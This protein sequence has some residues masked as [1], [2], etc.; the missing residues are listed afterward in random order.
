[1]S[2]TLDQIAIAIQDHVSRATLD[3]DYLNRRLRPIARLSLISA[4]RE[5]PPPLTLEDID[6]SPSS[7]FCLNQHS[8]NDSKLQGE[9][10]AR[11]QQELDENAGNRGTQGA[12]NPRKNQQSKTGSHSNVYGYNQ[13]SKVNRKVARPP[14]IE[15]RKNADLTAKR[16]N[17]GGSSIPKR[18]RLS[19]ESIPRIQPLSEV[20]TNAKQYFVTK[21]MSRAE[22]VCNWDKLD[23]LAYI[24]PSS[25][26][27]P[28]EELD[29]ILKQVSSWGSPNIQA[30]FRRSVY[31]WISSKERGL[32]ISPPEHLHTVQGFDPR[33]FQQFWTALHIV[34][35]AKGAEVM[36]VLFRRKAL[37][38]L[39]IAYHNVMNHIRTSLTNGAVLQ[40]NEKVSVRARTILYTTLYP[41]QT[42]RSRM[43]SMFNYDQRCAAPYLRLYQHFQN[44]GMLAMI[45]SKTFEGDLQLVHRQPVMIQILDLLR[46]DLQTGQRLAFYSRVINMLFE[47]NVPNAAILAELDCWTKEENAFI[48]RLPPSPFGI[49]QTPQDIASLAD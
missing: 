22:G 43:K 17:D 34:K 28:F 23:E 35:G 11:I 46:P 18:S 6:A 33:P 32:N 27:K 25:K 49:S 14:A 30:A 19:P 1:M 2:I 8:T 37:V 26:Q 39:S 40:N 38:N 44:D 41:E 13:R 16:S 3:I 29:I 42:D 48:C 4:T 24:D 12:G 47:G 7:S 31:A 20:Q 9:D 10:I 45:P 36:A 5:T 21:W 15:T